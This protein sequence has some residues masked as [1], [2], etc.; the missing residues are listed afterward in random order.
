MKQGTAYQRITI[1]ATIVSF[2]ALPFLNPQISAQNLVP[3][4]SFEAYD[5]CPENFNNFV[6]LSCAPWQLPTEGTADYFNACSYPSFASVPTNFI[7]SQY[8]QSGDGYCGF[9]LKYVTHPEYVEYIQAPL[10]EPM[11]AGKAY[12]VSF[13]VSLADLTC[14]TNHVGAYFS[15][16]AVESSG[17][18]HL[19]YI[20]QID[21]N[22][23]FISDT[24]GWTLVEGCFIAE[25]NFDHITLGN[26]HPKV[27][28]LSDPTCPFNGEVS[29][30]YIDD[31]FVEEIQPGA[32]DL[33]L[34]GPE[35]VCYSYEIN[36]GIPGVDY[37]WS[38]G[39]VEETLTV[40]S[41]GTYVLTIY[42]GCDAG[43]DS[44]EIEVTDSPPVILNPDEIVIC[45]GETIEFSL[46]PSLGQYVWTD[47][48]TNPS[49]TISTTGIYAVTLDDGCDLTSD[50]IH[51]TVLNPPEQF[52]LGGDTTVCL[53]QEIE[54]FLEPDLGDFTWQNNSHSNSFIITQGGFYSVTISNMCGEA[55]ADLEV[56]ETLIDPVALGQDETI[57]A[58]DSIEF[59]LNSNL[60]SFLWQDGSTDTLYQV[61]T[62]GLYSVTVSNIC[63]LNSDSIYVTVL[64]I[65]VI[66]FGDTIM[67]CPGDTIILSL[68]GQVG[69]YTWQDGSTNDSLL[70]IA[71]G[72]YSLVF[73]NACGIDSS[74]VDVMYQPT[75]PLSLGPDTS[76]CPGQFIILE[77]DIP[78][79]NILWSDGS[80]E[81]SL[82]INQPGTY[83]IQVSTA[84][85]TYFD[86]IFVATNSNP[87]V[88]DLPMTIDLCDGESVMLPSG[89]TGV[90]YLWNNGSTSPNL[91]VTSPGL[92]S[93]TVS[94]SC[95]VDSDSVVVTSAGSAPMVDL[96]MD[97]SLC[98]GQNILLT[99]AFSDVV[100]WLWQDSSTAES[101]MTDSPGWVIVEVLNNCGV[102]TDS[103]FIDLLPATPILNLGMDTSICPGDSLTLMANV[104]G[105]SILWSDGTTG[106]AITISDSAHVYATST[107][108]CGSFTDSI[109]IGLLPGLPLLNLGPDQTI[110]PGE[111]ITLT[112]NIIDVDFLWNNGST[113]SSIEV[114]DAQLVFLT[115]SNGCG[116]AVDSLDITERTDGPQIDL[117]PDQ[118]ACIGDTIILMSSIA[119][120]NFLWQDGTT[121]ATYPVVV[122]GEY[123]LTV[124]NLCGIATDTIEIDFS[125]QTPTPY[126]GSDTVLCTGATLVLEVTTNP[127][128]DLLWQ[129]G[130]TLSS[131]NVASGGTY[132]IQESNFCGI[133]YDS[134]SIQYLNPPD[135]FYLGH[136]TTLCPGDQ[137]MLTVPTGDF[138]I[139]W[140]NGSHHSEMLVETA[141]LY[142]VALSNICGSSID[143][144]MIGVD[145]QTPVL[146]LADEIKL[147]DGESI[148]IDAAQAFPSSYLWSS[149]Q[150]S[151]S[152]IVT[153]P[154][155][156][157]VH[158][159]T[160]CWMT[161]DEV[162]VTQEK[163]CTQL[164]MYV[165]NIFSPNGDQVNDYFKLSIGGNLNIQNF[166]A[167][168]FDR[169]GNL[170]FYSKDI[171]FNWDG[172]YRNT[173]VQSGVYVYV[174]NIEHHH[175]GADKTEILKGEVTLIR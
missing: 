121:L 37:Y 105:A 114:S 15:V 132:Q 61:T 157:S 166:S 69:N 158:V 7:G 126:L 86:T 107:N 56:F 140:Q 153:T 80:M 151:S 41:S 45:P 113:A 154:G 39:S 129:D 46:D 64:E 66:D 55:S 99:P 135:P 163:D 6:H 16:G 87:P 84:C 145:T 18:L 112:T 73:E 133:G 98:P 20:P 85:T 23:G 90:D 29:Y 9:Y 11:S 134:I 19:D 22:G 77:M 97:T 82:L 101:F 75:M 117:G 88:L 160:P 156:Y 139:L 42:D 159:A 171:D 72:N 123:I 143:S 95:G 43:V 130:S 63:G 136:D 57:C 26:F 49:Y 70:I 170:V 164:K 168:I 38:N 10:E 53:G 161:S 81:D 35:S 40:T 12:Y 147:C 79:A 175:E 17:F 125:V 65:P 71:P 172:T 36:P 24:A 148:V 47:G 2:I 14:G 54:I 118:I 104:S 173:P 131:I 111:T 116:T 74:N 150:Q 8:A 109:I 3:N 44:I 120:V 100:T 96:G 51:V 5:F 124:S 149:G 1:T 110:C 13:Y 50:S 4:P 21:H 103:L 102:T 60:G 144:I 91:M 83:S 94:N 152:I 58:G 78:G 155:L 162:I 122:S 108:T 142:V 115:I 138:D 32:L 119:G 31:I 67:L 165:P 146:N 25:D 62:E 52:T 137:I 59:N 127:L 27:N 34:G 93:L 169:W 174:I 68:N 141:G 28:T 33:E 128:N 167:S 92:Y 30:Y 76:I 48:S 106:S 89:I